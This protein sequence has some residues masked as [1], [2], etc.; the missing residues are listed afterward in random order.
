MATDKEKLRSVIG[1]PDPKAT[2][3]NTTLRA[4]ANIPGFPSTDSIP[5]SVIASTA[6]KMSL[7]MSMG[8]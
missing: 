1:I 4:V 5:T 2:P 8:M 7:G 3:D 6:I